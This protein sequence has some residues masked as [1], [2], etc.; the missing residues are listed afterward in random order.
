M[1][2]PLQKTSNKIERLL[3]HSRYL[4]YLSR[5]LLTYIPKEFADKICVLGFSNQFSRHFS[6]QKGK[7]DL[8]L[9]SISPS[10]ASKLRFYIPALKHSLS[11]EPQFGQI[12]KIIIRILTPNRPS[13]SL[14]TK[15]KKQPLYSESS[16]D[17]IQN[18]AHHIDNNGLKN[19]LMHLAHNVGKNT[20]K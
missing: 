2:K 8:I 6:D 12:Q 1:K 5:R 14:Q 17:I 19:A 3:Q 11:A 20:Q 13:N 16:A 7:R 9:A 15:D 18:S 10:W 4:D